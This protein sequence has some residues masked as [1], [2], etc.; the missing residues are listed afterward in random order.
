M[1]FSNWENVDSNGESS[2]GQRQ[3]KQVIS[4][5]SSIQIVFER[6]CA[7]IP[8][9]PSVNMYSRHPA[10]AE[11]IFILLNSPSQA[12]VAVIITCILQRWVE[13]E[14]EER[15]KRTSMSMFWQHT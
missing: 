14:S 11:N 7:Q 12:R 4:A 8:T 9:C 3:E 6:P 5:L 15:S 13:C 10:C 2:R 1:V